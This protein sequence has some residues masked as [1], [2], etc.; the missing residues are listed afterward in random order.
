MNSKTKQKTEKPDLEDVYKY[1]TQWRHDEDWTDFNI[2]LDSGDILL[3][4]HMMMETGAI[5]STACYDWAVPCEIEVEKLAKE[6]RRLSKAKQSKA[7]DDAFEGCLIFD[8]D[9]C[10]HVSFLNNGN[11]KL[12]ADALRVCWGCQGKNVTRTTWKRGQWK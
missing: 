1:L 6:F 9:D 10:S 8:C 7:Y 3:M 12:Y 5:D 4:S 11:D 2:A